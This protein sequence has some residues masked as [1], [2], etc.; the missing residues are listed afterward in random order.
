M[1]NPL[2]ISDLQ[3]LQYSSLLNSKTHPIVKYCDVD[4]FPEMYKKH[5][6]ESAA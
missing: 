5:F 4:N 3:V 6:W 2:G 1:I